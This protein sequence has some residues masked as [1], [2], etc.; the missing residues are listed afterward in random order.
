MDPQPRNTFNV[1]V[2]GAGLSGLCLAQSLKKSRIDVHVYNATTLPK[3]EDRATE[4]RWTSEGFAPWKFAC[5]TASSHCSRR[6]PEP[7][8]ASFAL[9]GEICGRFSGSLSQHQGPKAGTCHARP[10]GR[11]CVK[12]FCVVSR[13]RCLLASSARVSRPRPSGRRPTLRMTRPRLQ[14]FWSAR[15]GPARRSGR[16]SCRMLSRS[17]SGTVRSMEG[18]ISTQQIIH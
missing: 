17:R 8:V 14:R 1:A 11:H 13:I 6:R 18:R 2:I 4:S 9:R 7:P 15:T 16:R 3:H 5:L 12:F 10:T